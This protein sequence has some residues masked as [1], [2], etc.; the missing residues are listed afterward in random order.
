MVQTTIWQ[1]KRSNEVD[2]QQTFR[3]GLRCQM[4]WFR[5]TKPIEMTTDWE[6]NVSKSRFN[7]GDEYYQDIAREIEKQLFGR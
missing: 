1:V 3:S 6:Y 4:R 5:W 2:S 7:F